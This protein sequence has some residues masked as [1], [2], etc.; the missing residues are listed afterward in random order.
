M[1]IEEAAAAGEV[2]EVF[3]PAKPELA[4]AKGPILTTRNVTLVSYKLDETTSSED[5]QAA[6]L[7]DLYNRF[8]NT[9]VFSSYDQLNKAISIGEVA[10]GTFVLIENKDLGGIFIVVA[11]I[12]ATGK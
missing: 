6:I 1:P 3:Q 11:K 7:T 10:V 5:T 12:R 9:P 2:K 4:R 8:Q